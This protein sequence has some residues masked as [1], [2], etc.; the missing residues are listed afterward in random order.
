MKYFWENRPLQYSLNLI[1]RSLGFTK[2][3]FHKSLK[4]HFGRE[5]EKRYLLNLILQIRKDHP[6]M[7][8]RA[9]HYKL[10]PSRFGR[11]RFIE[12]CRE[13]GFVGRRTRSRRITT[14]STGVQRF[15]NLLQGRELTDIDQAW[16]SDITYFEIDNQFYYLTF[17]LDCYSRRIIGY[18]AS[19]RLLTKQT[20]LPSIQMAVKLRGS[21][22]KQGVIFH[23][24][25]GGQYY[26]G[27]FLD[28]TKQHYFKNSMCEFGW[29]NGKAE[30][31]N[32]VI[33][34]NYLRHFEIKNYVQLVRQ[35]DRAVRLYNEEKPH[36]SLGRKTPVEFEKQLAILH[37]QN[38]SV[39]K[40]SFDVKDQYCGVSNPTI[41]E[42][43]QA[44]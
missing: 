43:K 8:C 14:D 1:Y 28:F 23:S 7:C 10:N 5:E 4:N 19:K 37:K 27:G 33:K 30:R 26:H 13:Y 40:N 20:T 34:N 21:E 39:M 17:I 15:V 32:G 16:S 41:S 18:R 9:M 31:I 29:E 25:G 3:G 2:Q 44:I 36:V 11:D 12:L 22:F 6:T 42:A 35:L 24:D 38:K